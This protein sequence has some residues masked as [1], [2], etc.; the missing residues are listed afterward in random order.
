MLIIPKIE[1]NC[2]QYANATW[3]QTYGWFQSYQGWFQKHWEFYL[4]SESFGITTKENL[5]FSGRMLEQRCKREGSHDE[6]KTGA[7]N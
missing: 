4:Q 2:R 1:A 6:D 3:K 5:H 7:R